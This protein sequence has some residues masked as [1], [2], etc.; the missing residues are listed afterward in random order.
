MYK[1]NTVTMFKEIIGDT[2]NIIKKWNNWKW[3]GL[4]LK[5]YKI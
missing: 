3:S 4:Y 1:T 5:G 2:E